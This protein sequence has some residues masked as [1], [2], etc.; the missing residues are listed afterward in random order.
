M[1]IENNANF[2]FQFITHLLVLTCDKVEKKG[3]KIVVACYTLQRNVFHYPLMEELIILGQYS[4]QLRPVIT[5]AGFFTVNRSVLSSVASTL[6]TY[7]IICVQFQAL[8]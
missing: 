4:K 3:K 1:L 8:T 2:L 7:L 6:V 5:A